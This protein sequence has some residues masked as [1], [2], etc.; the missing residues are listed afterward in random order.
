MK[1]TLK[2]IV[3]DL[4]AGNTDCLYFATEAQIDSLITRG[5]ID[6][7]YAYQAANYREE[8]NCLVN[9]AQIEFG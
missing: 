9:S 6:E 2:S 8:M 3:A 4:N 5:N 1:T 7:D